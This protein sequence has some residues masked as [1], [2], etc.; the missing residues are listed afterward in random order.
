MRGGQKRLLTYEVSKQCAG[1]QSVGDG[2][3]S[4][5]N[6][7]APPL[8]TEKKGVVGLEGGWRCGGGYRFV[9]N[10]TRKS[11]PV[12]LKREKQSIIVEMI[13]D[14]WFVSSL[15]TISPIVCVRDFFLGEGDSQFARGEKS[16][17]LCKRI[18]REDF[19]G[20]R[21]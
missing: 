14:C 17:G 1:P 5:R 18:S 2:P 7:D 10:I 12:H 15:S 19:G 11:W 6:G 3:P 13:Q 21:C 8:S 9:P 16:V 20:G 4:W